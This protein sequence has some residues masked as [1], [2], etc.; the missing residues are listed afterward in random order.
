M[1]RRSEAVY[2]KRLIDKLKIMFPNC[3]IIKNDPELTQ[4]IPD[5]LILFDNVWA[6]LE[7][8]AELDSKLQPNQQYYIE[9][10]SEM[11]FCSLI[12]PAIEEQVLHDLQQ[13]F[14]VG[15]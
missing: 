11:S 3:F 10:F 2:Q 6:M 13:T 4:G 8:K 7:V 12:N 15:R 9:Y 5:L 14:G 1:I